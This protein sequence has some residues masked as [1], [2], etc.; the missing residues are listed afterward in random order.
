MGLKD[1]AIS[2]A[3][4]DTEDEVISLLKEAGYWDNSIYWRPFGST[5]NNFSTIGN[6]QSAPDSAL[7]EKLINSVDAVLMKECLIRDIEPE[8]PEAPQ[9]ISQALQQFFNIRDGKISNLDIKERN[10]MSRNIIMAATGSRSKPNYVI[11][12]CGEGQTPK[13]MPD[14]ILS[15]GKSNKLRVPFVQ[16][17][18]NMGGTGV[19]Q[20]CGNHNLQLIITKRCPQIICN[21]DETKDNWG[22][23]VVRRDNPS[24]GRRSSMY[25]Y[26]TNEE[27][28]ILNFEADSLKI[29]PST[30]EYKELEYG[31]FIKLFEYNMPK[32][33]TNIVFD[34]NY[35]LALLMPSLAHPV[36]LI[37]CRDYTGHTLESTLSGLKIRLTDDKKDNVEQ[38]FPIPLKF[39][40]D[41]QKFNASIYVFKENY[42]DRNYRTDEGIIFSLNGQTHGSLKKSFFK[43]KSLNFSY[44]AESL[45]IIVDCSNIDGRTRED[46]F[47]NSRDRLRE[48]NLK[49]R[50]EKAFED[51]LSQHEALRALQEERR[52]KAVFNRLNNEKPLADI[53]NDILKKS[54]TLSKLF[55]SGERLQ[56]P[57]N[58]SNTGTKS[59]FKGK[60]YPTYFVLQN[61]PKEGVYTRHA[62]IN[63]K[64]RIQ[65]ETDVVNDYFCRE[66][67]PGEYTLTYEGKECVGH[68]LNLY[69]GIATLTVTI[70]SD[71]VI[72]DFVKFKFTVNDPCT[73][74]RFDEEWITIIEPSQQETSGGKGKRKQ[75]AGLGPRGNRG[76]PAGLAMPNIIELTRDDWAQYGLTKEDALMIKT[77]EDLY[78]FF[79][80]M[81]NIHL[82]T[83]IKGLKD[84]SKI[85]LLQARYKYSIVLIGL[86]VLNYSK[87]RNNEEKEEW[88]TEEFVN[89]VANMLSPIVLPLIESMSDLD[90]E[91]M[92]PSDHYITA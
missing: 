55:I 37:E 5:E 84:D 8:S 83:E 3:K 56:N 68:G 28:D 18:F 46:L 60:K 38:G 90:I 21:N 54:P 89:N 10:A 71:V 92:F 79:I 35:R 91:E 15:L 73:M 22:I 57:F 14:T 82:Q 86:S 19:L 31:M 2:L 47:M 25:T 13:K 4:S 27:G 17:K 49:R 87:N 74:T 61:K 78:D 69:N 88:D 44:L 59:I 58:L 72:G 29:I 43:R 63:N 40:I 64:F 80:N 39:D 76:K 85:N 66:V 75:P 1:L 9:T 53:L 41:G 33:R 81:D 12:D 16:G 65:F 30:R 26:L 62:P 7:V 77:N 45:L 70:P 42:S 32:L 67:D 6:Q 36:R 48:G 24:K 23:T 50:I 52:R 11:V 51:Y 20:F 34:L